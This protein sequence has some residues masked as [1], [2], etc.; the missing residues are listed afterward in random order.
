MSKFDLEKALIKLNW[1]YLISIMKK[2]VLGPN[3]LNRSNIISPQSNDQYLDKQR[4]IGG[5]L[6]WE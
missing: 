5:F 4:A 2:M 3:G 6:S 1:S